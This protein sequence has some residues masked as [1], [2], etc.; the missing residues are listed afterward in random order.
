MIKTYNDGLRAAASIARGYKG[1]AER[2]R[3]ATGRRFLGTEGAWAS[4]RDEERGEDITAER[5][6]ALILAAQEP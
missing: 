1:S 4:I 5:I 3:K 2:D 6:A